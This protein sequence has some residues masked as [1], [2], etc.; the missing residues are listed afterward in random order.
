MFVIV[1]M[2]NWYAFDCGMTS[3][4]HNY[5]YFYT[6]RNFSCTALSIFYSTGYYYNNYLLN[7]RFKSI[8]IVNFET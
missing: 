5:I 1:G 8:L 2:H 7:S 3:Y 6:L 4:L